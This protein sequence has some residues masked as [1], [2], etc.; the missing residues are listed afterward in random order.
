MFDF[1]SDLDAYFCEKYANY[2]KLC[3]LSGY[4][5][6]QMKATRVLENGRTYAYTLP[7][8][9]MRLATQENKEDILKTLKENVLDKSF[10]FSFRPCGFFTRFRNFFVKDAFY[11]EWK[12]IFEKYNIS[13]EEAHSHLDVAEEVWENIWKG[14]F[15]PT[16][17]LLYS[18]ALTSH[19]SYEDTKMLLAY[20]DEG[21]DFRSEK[22]VVVSYLLE[23]KVYNPEM[24]NVALREYKIINLFIKPAQMVDK[25]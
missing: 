16:K 23:Q 20:C 5:M 3:T 1:L 14:K 13:K 7:S 21:F 19:I 25:Q 18:F 24:V 9:T 12:K 17:N 10:S 4:Q 22:D 11:K 8:E 2:D 6:P 15:L